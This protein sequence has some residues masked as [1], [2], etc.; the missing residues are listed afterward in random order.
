MQLGEG[1]GGFGVWAWR[2]P[3]RASGVSRFWAVGCPSA[4][5]R[6]RLA[7]A[8]CDVTSAVSPNSFGLFQM[9]FVRARRSGGRPYLRTVMLIV[10]L[11]AAALH[12]RA[13]RVAAQ[14]GQPHEGCPKSRRDK[15]PSVGSIILER[16]SSVGRRVCRP[17]RA[18]RGIARGAYARTARVHWARLPGQRILLPC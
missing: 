16:V 1:R 13:W 14:R 7:C 10:L 4:R 9:M 2:Q 3:L 11:P 8:H 5:S 12:G 6:L 18:A 17:L 15:S